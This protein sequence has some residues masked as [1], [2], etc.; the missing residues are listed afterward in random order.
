VST[1]PSG[2]VT[3]F[4]EAGVSIPGLEGGVGCNPRVNFDGKVRNF[5]SRTICL[6]SNSIPPNLRTTDPTSSRQSTVPATNAIQRCARGGRR[7]VEDMCY[8]IRRAEAH[9]D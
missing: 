9:V 8:E 5:G 1:S 4:G 2:Y 7:T 3:T 6:S